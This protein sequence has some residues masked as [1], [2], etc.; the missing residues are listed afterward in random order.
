[1]SIS[2]SECSKC[3]ALNKINPEKALTSPPL[4]G[5]CGSPLNIHGLVSEV[6]TQNFKKILKMATSPI[7][8]DFW[9]S[10]CGPCRTYGPE[11]QKASL[12]NQNIIFLKINTESEQQISME[13]GIRGI[14]C[15]LLFKDGK[16]M[17]RQ[18][19]VMNTSQIKQFIHKTISA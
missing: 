13:F 3:Q 6:N 9:A 14:P 4:C 8:V 10:W 5:K 11:Y 18:S 15:T 17:N 2:F 19:G 1:M 12:E 7:I 16:E